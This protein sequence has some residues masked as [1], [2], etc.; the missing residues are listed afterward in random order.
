MIR[1]L[2]GQVVIREI[3]EASGML[4]TPEPDPRSVKTHRGVVLAMGAPARTSKGVEVPHG[5]QVGDVVQY[6]WVHRERDYTRPWTDGE[7]ACWIPQEC[8][9]GVIE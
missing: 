7:P 5:F 2:R 8:V 9:D 3:K 6:H 1:P 4:W